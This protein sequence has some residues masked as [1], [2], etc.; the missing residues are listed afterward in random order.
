LCVIFLAQR[1]VAWSSALLEQ[2]FAQWNALPTPTG[3]D[4]G[5][6]WPTAC[7]LDCTG[8]PWCESPGC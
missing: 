8:A 6:D 2:V 1:I 5:P 7:S 4:Q 3:V